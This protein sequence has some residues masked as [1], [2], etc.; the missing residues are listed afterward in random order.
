MKLKGQSILVTGGSRGIGRGV[1]VGLAREGADVAV[2]YVERADAA[3]EVVKE[4]ESLGRRALAVK[5]N[6]SK[7][8][9]VNAMVKTIVDAWGRIDVLVNN[10]GVIVFKDFFD[11]TEEDWD[12]IHSTNLKGSFLV[13]QAVAKEMV[14]AGGGRIVFVNSEAGIKAHPVISAYNASKGGQLMLMRSVAL[15]LA[16]HKIRVNSVLPFCVP[17][18]QNAERMSDPKMVEAIIDAT[19]LGRLGTPEDVLHAIVYLVSEDSSWMTGASISLD[20][21]FTIT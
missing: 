8:D 19:P 12:W 10:A 14:K 9:E 17:T 15:A 6:V 3:E 16:P 4:I 21:G 5:A 18:D 13:T 20:G 7:R 2:N 11:T 1:A